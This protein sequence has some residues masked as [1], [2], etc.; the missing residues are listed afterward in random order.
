MCEHFYGPLSK[1]VFFMF[2]TKFLSLYLNDASDHSESGTKLVKNVHLISQRY[3]SSHFSRFLKKPSNNLSNELLRKLERFRSRFR[4]FSR[5]QAFVS[6]KSKRPK[7][8]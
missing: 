8:S 7:V 6:L 5:L 3:F 4:R 1:H 2:Y